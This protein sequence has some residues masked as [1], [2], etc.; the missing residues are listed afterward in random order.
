MQ[1]HP[2]T[3]LTLVRR[4]IEQHGLFVRGDVV[5][6]AVSGGPD[7]MAMLHALAWWRDRMGFAVVAHGVDH[8]LRVEARAE[9]DLAEKVAKSLNVAF[10]R[11]QLA[12]APGGNL[13]ARARSAR[14][15]ALRSAADA[16]GARWIATAHHADDRAET[17]LLR[18]LRGAGP[19]G[20]AA[21][22]PR[23]GS[24]VRPLLLARRSDVLAHLERHGVPFVHD[25]SNDD[26]RFDRVRVR[27]E[28]MPVLTALSPSIV[29]HLCDLAEMLGNEQLSTGIPDEL[30]I[31]LP[32]IS[33]LGRRTRLALTALTA[34]ATTTSSAREA[35][36]QKKRTV[37]LPGGLV[38]TYD[39]G[40][41][42][43]VVRQT[44]LSNSQSP[45][46]KR[47]DK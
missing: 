9:L 1:S 20:L 43:I 16:A 47:S 15:E 28:L 18:L 3:L 36:R 35:R 23:A 22:P 39:E 45:E 44:S 25:P 4:C 12:V 32:H 29:T 34:S 27:R 5:V 31:E 41:C 42:G 14:Q 19:R 33:A 38:A 6:A 24:W 11:T 10:S 40:Q 7:S 37:A 46:K 2:P 8:G 17:V 21:L 13:Q 26:S 30:S